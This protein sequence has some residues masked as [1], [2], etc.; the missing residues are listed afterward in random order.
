MT[1]G[2]ETNRRRAFIKGSSLAVAAAWLRGGAGTNSGRAP[3][4][5]NFS[6]KVETTSGKVQGIANTG[7]KEVQGH[8]LR[9]DPPAARIDSCLR[10]KTGSVDGA[11]RA[12]ASGTDKSALRP[13]LILA[14]RLRHDD[15]VGPATG[16]HGRGLPG[17][18][19]VGRRASTTAISAQSWCL[20]HGGGICDRLGQR[21]LDLTA[22]N[23]RNSAT[24]VVVTVEIIGWPSFGYLHLA[25][26]GRA[27]R[28]CKAPEWRG[29]D[30][31]GGIAR[32]GARQH[33]KIRRRF[34]RTS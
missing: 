24:S 34:R 30:G 29:S 26:P 31:S 22:L 12:S 21:L 2:T 17:V 20:S 6:G 16:R 19:C 7:I 4:P 15:P 25:E 5:R 14:Q 13:S 18:E 23:W 10:G 9:R 33:R 27:A 32:V 1:N 11:C 8:S 28:V 3:P